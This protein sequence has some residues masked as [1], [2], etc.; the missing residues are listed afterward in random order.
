MA[1]V[2]RDYPAPP[3]VP[4]DAPLCPAKLILFCTNLF[5]GLIGSQLIAEWMDPSTY[6]TWKAV[7]KMI[8][9]FCVSYIMIHVGFEFEIDKQRVRQYGTEYLVAMT[10]AGFPW[11]FCA[12][13][14]MY[15]LGDAHNLGW[16]EALIAA[17][18]AA[19]TSAGIL[20]TML[21]AA[22]L[23]ETWLFKKARVLAIFDDLDTLLLMVPLKAIFVGLKW[24]LSIDLIF[25]GTL[26][27]LMWVFM[28]KFKVPVTWPYIVC[29][30]ASVAILCEL[31]HFLTSSSATD[32]HDYADT[33]HLEVLLPAFTVGCVI[34]HVHDDGG[35]VVNRLSKLQTNEPERPSCL[36][37][38]KAIP[39]S[40]VK[41]SISAVF[42]VLVGFSMPSLFTDKHDTSGGHRLLASSDDHSADE[43]TMPAEAYVQHVIVCT[44]LMNIGKTFPATQYRSEVSFRTRLALAVAMMP[45]GEVCAGIIVNALAL[46][47]KGPAMTIA[48]FCLATNMMMVSGFIFTVKA[49]IKEKPKAPPATTADTAASATVA[50]TGPKAG[51]EPVSPEA[52]TVAGVQEANQPANMP[53]GKSE[54][55]AAGFGRQTTPLEKVS[56]MIDQV[57]RRPS[58]DGSRR[59]SKE[60]QQE[61][62]EQ[63]EGLLSNTKVQM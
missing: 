30:A 7:V 1:E 48:V 15:G 16:K 36:E 24:E 55:E 45:R 52:V 32:P 63:G 43:E 37:R 31:V 61:N 21:E 53:I 51:N 9:M 17:R 49:L 57:R 26:L 8:T 23:G 44:I 20:F 56:E 14:F 46:G 47:I 50:P 4:K 13:Y 11:V 60:Q 3:I 35:K 33:V 42:M 19:P 10:A 41:S 58:K 28:H 12:I 18:F 5:I 54:E 39:A 6:S 27:V 38:I 59:P 62:K 40:T 29:Y 34:E 2:E 25:V 22:G